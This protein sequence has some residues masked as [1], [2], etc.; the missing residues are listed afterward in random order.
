MA[1]E[2]EIVREQVKK[3][4]VQVKTPKEKQAVEVEENATVKKFKEAI[5]VK[6]SNAPVDNLCLIFAGKIMK[7]QET[8]NVH[9]VKDG[10]TVHLVIKQAAGS[11]AAS[12]AP[13]V[14]PAPQPT[15]GPGIGALP[16]AATAP[17][18]DIAASPFGLG[19]FGGIPGL[20]NLGMGS[21]NFMEMQQRMQRD[22]MSNPDM[23]R[24][25]LDNPLT[26]SL[27]SNPDVI[28][29]M[30]E[31]NPQMQEVMERNPEIRQMLNNPEVLRQM[32]EIARNPSRLQE[33]TRTMDRQMQN[34]EAMPG[35]MNILQRMYRD[36]Q[37]PVLN[38]MGGPNPFQDLRGANN[39]PAPTPSTE[40]VEPAP[41]PWAG[42]S[43][44]NASR[45][46]GS[47]TTPSTTTTSSAGGLGATLGQNSGM[48]TSPGMQSLMGQMRDN[49]TLMSQM[50]SAP[51]MQSMFSS[52]AANPDQAASMLSSNPLFAGNPA[53]QQQMSTMMP[54]LLQQMQNPQ[55]Q[56][57]MGNSDAMQAIMQIQQ[58]LERLRSTAPDL[59]QTMGL[60]SMPPNLVPGAT[61]PTSPSAA[62][63]VTT[64]T[65]AS[66]NPTS[67]ATGAPVDLAGLA[68][69][70]ALG[71]GGVNPDMFSSFMTQM[72]GQMRQGDASQPPEERFA[73]QLDQLA[74][75]GFVDRQANV[76]ALIAT[77]G[78]VNAAVERL[79]S[80]NVQGQSLG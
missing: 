56:Q 32:M 39:A 19:G 75:M 6:F 22:L 26:Q 20:G 33:M 70:P 49:P 42:S 61:N 30:L 37:E 25:V 76:Q 44:S 53:L 67:P 18:P 14:S 34:L 11:S 47:S 63:P 65:S 68:A 50:M 9:N 3:I 5:S 36:V 27:M 80:T 55:V 77:M 17:A 15:P 79:L 28:R 45:T 12:P 72:M 41:N 29:Q 43:S 38:A 71:G 73:S 51:Y 10:M 23:L 78:D 7:D 54:Q 60:P 69:N 16:P 21:A 35:G 1:D 58:G 8:L 2:V 40:T 48:F 66:S 24:Q 64:T 62:P 59:F 4:T 46:T 31:S 13:S 57:L 74:S 52:L